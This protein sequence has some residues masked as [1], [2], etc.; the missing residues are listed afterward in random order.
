MPIPTRQ[1]DSGEISGTTSN[2]VVCRKGALLAIYRYTAM[3]YLARDAGPPLLLFVA[4][5]DEIRLWAGV[6][7]KA[8]DYL[9]GFQ[10]SLEASRVEE[11]TAY[12]KEDLRNVSPTAVVVGLRG[13]STVTDLPG[14]QFGPTVR[15][16]EVAIELPEYE[17]W[18]MEELARSAI[19]ILESRLSAESVDAI[20][21]RI[22]DAVSEAQR[23]EDEDEVDIETSP[24]S[25]NSDEIERLDR[26][27]LEEFYA[28]LVGYLKSLTPWPDES[29]LREV[30]YSLLKPAIIV[31]GQHRVFGAAHYD[32]TMPLAVCAMPQSDWA[33]NVYQFVV[34]NQ[35]AKPIKP[36]FL[37][38]I[39]ATSLSQTE[40][41]S[42]YK[43]LSVSNIDVERSEIM[44]RVNKDPESPFRG[45]VDFEVPGSNGFLSFPG[46]WRL[47][48]DF[49]RIPQT[50]P[51]LLEG[52]SWRDGEPTWLRFFFSFWEGIR[53]AFVQRDARLWE[54]PTPSN[55]N[56]LLKIVA[57][58]EMQRVTLD[59]WAD[60][61]M[62][63][64]I[65]LEDVREK[66]RDFWRDFPTEFFTDEWKQKGLQT[67]VG[68]SLLRD[69]LTQTRR[70]HGQHSWGHR[71]LGLFKDASA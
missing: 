35:K 43:R 51:V 33:E 6:P 45:M 21:G 9:H 20:N 18:S 13:T 54:R 67:Q 68:R 7:R 3:Q 11:V 71:R 25:P 44:E 41:D 26:S 12:Y 59:L 30:L 2:R 50:Y 4:P 64:L 65:S 1:V 57:L 10:R 17:N 27:Y 48:V 55:P 58:Q 66:A 40:L 62:L 32:P 39:I 53:C 29:K 52:G 36:A 31:D 42:V 34:I 8:F 19:A 46:L 61:R 24:G 49:K 16:V 69:A 15:G 22:E 5:A 70:K 28:Q 38:A 60:A 56:N 37:S 47:A 63:R 14:V 23:L